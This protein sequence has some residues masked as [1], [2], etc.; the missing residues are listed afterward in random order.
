MLTEVVRHQVLLLLAR[1][2]DA[3]ATGEH[4]KLVIAALN[5][6]AW[7]R[8]EIALAAIARRSQRRGK[9]GYLKS[10][11]GVAGTGELSVCRGY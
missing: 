5:G 9:I 2:R 7:R 6:T 8:L 1:Q 3:V 11:S 4:S 10:T